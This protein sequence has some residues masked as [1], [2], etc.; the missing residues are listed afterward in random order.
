MPLP[1]ATKV[2]SLFAFAIEATDGSARAGALRTPH[3]EVPTPAFLP[4]GTLGSVKALDPQDLVA[5]RTR[6]VLANAYHLY[7]R[8]GVDVVERLGGLHGFMGWQGP[9]LTDSGGFQG[10]SLEHLREITEDAIVFK[11]HIDGSVHTFTPEA[12][13]QYQEALGADII[14]PLDLCVA[15]DADRPAVEEAVERTSRWAIR[16]R[17]A[18]ARDDQMMFGIV[19]GGLFE[20]LRQ[21]SAESITSL[22][23]PGYAIG[24]LS[25]GESK[26][27]MY[28]ATATTAQMLPVE[29]PRY[30]MG[31]GSPED[32]VECVARGVDL[33]DCALP[34]RIAR[35]GAMF[36]RTGRVNIYNAL[37]KNQ[38]A[39][40]EDGCDCYT[41]RTF[42]AAYVHH[43]FR[44]KE[45]LAYRLSR[46]HNLR[47]VL[48][49]MEEMR[50][51]IKEARLESYRAE[52]LDRF[53]P[54]DEET[55]RTQRRKWEDAQRRRRAPS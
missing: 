32:L 19:Q 5:I 55:R 51:A 46:V 36:V 1:S 35:S 26:R 42:S 27:E 50:S 47:F 37:F 21:R 38:E 53:V 29:S 20:D 14:M 3:G 10:F 49:L 48:R 25:V 7:L 8:P 31:V 54:T 18:Q 22:G 28:E 9:M 11:S 12:S 33:F 24:G 4:V 34:T 41:C 52:F 2:G 16:C 45:L 39:P 17:G 44:S 43:L 30:L 13:V 15:S 6:I 23:F 40:I